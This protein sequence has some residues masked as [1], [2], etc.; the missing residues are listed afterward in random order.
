MLDKKEFVKIQEDLQNFEIN[1][2]EVIQKSRDT[3]K[4]SKLIIYSLHRDDIKQASLII[5]DIKEKIKSLSLICYDTNINQT[6]LQEYAEA[7]CYFEFIKNKKIPIPKEIGI[8]SINY[9][10]GLSDLTGELMRKAV[11]EAINNNFLQV[12]EIKNLIEEIYCQF[13]QLNLRNG[14]LRKKSDAIKWNLQKVE[15]IIY[16]AEIQGRL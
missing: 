5:K 12:I 7:I 10:C 6:A 8:D 16:S 13:L 15:E 14:E 4:L 9:L 2:E 3:I 1:R 11:N